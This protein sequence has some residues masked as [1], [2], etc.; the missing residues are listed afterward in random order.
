MR[1][2]KKAIISEIRGKLDGC[3]YVLL[4]DCRGLTVEQMKALRGQLREAQ[5]FLMVV[6]NSMFAQA[7]RELGWAGMDAF[8][9]GP[10]AMVWGRGDISGVAKVVRTFA[11]KT[12]DLPAFK[13]GRLGTRVLSSGD[14]EA[15]AGLPPR[16]VMLGMLA[17]TLA[18]P[19]SRLVGVMNRKVA[20]LVYVLNAIAEKKSGGK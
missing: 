10:T 1:P 3:G 13:G 2:E 5:G 12:S 9:L 6:P 19:I 18:A 17:G 7:T 11:K 16:I 14:V 8:L 4:A 15:I 20:T